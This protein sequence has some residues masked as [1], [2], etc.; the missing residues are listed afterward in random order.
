LTVI[1]AKTQP[2]NT[3]PTFISIIFIATTIL[4]IAFFYKAAQHCKVVLLI[5]FCWV[6]LQTVLGLK[7]FYTNTA[8]IPP[9]LLLLVVPPIFTIAALFITTKGRFF[10]DSLNIKYLTILHIVRIPVE[11]VLFW[12]F[13]NKTVP[14][15]MT[16]EGRNF[17]ILAGITAPVIYYFSFIKSKIGKRTMIIWNCIC[18]ILLIN[19][20]INAALSTPSVLQQFAFKQPNIAI[21]YFPFNLLPAVIVPLVLL[22]HLVSI[23]QL[24]NRK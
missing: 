23:R 12:L 20:V 24:L 3:L 4:T 21:L 8:T 6:L 10:I 2:M 17:D 18:L 7:G 9:R 13:L 16:F 19:I 22:S 14:Q 5:L 11:L 15:L 1:C